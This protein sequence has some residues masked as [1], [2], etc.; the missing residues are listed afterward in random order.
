MRHFKTIERYLETTGSHQAFQDVRYWELNQSLDE[1][2]LRK[3]FLNIHVELLHGLSE[4]LISHRRPTETVD[5]RVERTIKNTIYQ[6]GDLWY[7]TEISIEY[8]DNSYAH[9]LTRHRSF[10]DALAEAVKKEFDIGDAFACKSMRKAEMDP[11]FRT[12]S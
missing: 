6:N 10:K 7:K 5:D 12:G 2:L 8:S 9:W 4:I 11:E 3:I 1:I